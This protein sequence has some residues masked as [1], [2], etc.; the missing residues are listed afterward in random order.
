MCARE[1]GR[2]HS[3]QGKAGIQL[4]WEAT[5]LPFLFPKPPSSLPKNYQLQSQGL[6][7]H[8]APPFHWT[9]LPPAEGPVLIRLSLE[10]IGRRHLLP[11]PSPALSPLSLPA[12]RLPDPRSPSPC[13]IC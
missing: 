11:P 2:D 5:L 10:D 8:E 9:A 12:N 1:Q 7:G 4:D 6:G 3:L 13:S